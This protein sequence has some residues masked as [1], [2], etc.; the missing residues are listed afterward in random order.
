MKRAIV[1]SGGGAKGAYEAGFLLVC[2]R[3]KPTF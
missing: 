2:K 3:I 1:L